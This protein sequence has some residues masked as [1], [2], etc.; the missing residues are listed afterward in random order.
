MDKQHQ[1]FVDDA[2]PGA[3]PT[4]F[5]HSAAG[6]SAQWRHQLQHLRDRGIR[7]IAVDLP[8]HGRSPAATN[9]APEAVAREVL[10]ALRALGLTDF[11]VVGHS[12]GALVAIALTTLAPKAVRGLFLL[13]AASDG[14]A[15]PKQQ[16]AGLMAALRADTL[17]TTSAYYGTLLAAARPD[18]REEVLATMRRTAAASIVGTFESLLHFDAVTPL[19]AFEGPRFALITS[20]NE[21]PASLQRLVKDVPSAR[22]DNVGH[23]LQLDEPEQ[24]NR[25]LDSF[26]SKCG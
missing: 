20:H 14:R 13:D 2:G 12:Y 16:A 23:W 8:G 22:V 26:L 1:L 25:Q 19:A 6:E 5:L 15:M 7:A 11:V 18:V 17:G 10:A 21:T 9:F 3:A 4:V 24:V